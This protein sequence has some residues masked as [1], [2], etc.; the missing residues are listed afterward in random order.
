MAILLAAIFAVSATYIFYSNFVLLERIG[1]PVD[2]NVTPEIKIGFNLNNDSM[3]FGKLPRGGQGVRH[4]DITNSYGSPVGIKVYSVG[5]IEEML[6]TNLTGFVLETG[7][8]RRISAKV[9]VPEDYS[10]GGYSGTLIL[11]IRK[12]FWLSKSG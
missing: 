2:V 12:A 1:I 3:H 7:K 5:S 10:P 8:T 11:E 6:S 4:I 9:T